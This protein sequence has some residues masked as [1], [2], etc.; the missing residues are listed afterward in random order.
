[1]SSAPT[2]HYGTIAE[3]TILIVLLYHYKEDGLGWPEVTLYIDNEEVVTWGY[4]RNPRFWNVK[5]YMVHNYDLWMATNSLLNSIHLKVNFEWI[6]GHQQFDKQNENILPILLNT[7]VD[8]LATN[9]YTKQEHPPHR[10][11]FHLGVVCFHQKGFHVQHISNSISARES[12]N[13]LLE[14]YLD[15]G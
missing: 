9:Q 7:E 2:E 8:K 13:S 1:M 15:H 6:Q 11:T 10:G 3:I 14:Y 4:I 12:D 5:Q